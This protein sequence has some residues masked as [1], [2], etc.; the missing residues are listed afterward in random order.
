MSNEPQLY[1][2]ARLKDVLDEFGGFP[3]EVVIVWFV[4]E[5]RVSGQTPII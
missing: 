3:G 2:L 5:I 4:E 1:L